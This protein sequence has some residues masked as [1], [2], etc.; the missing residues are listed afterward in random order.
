LQEIHLEND[1]NLHPCDLICVVKRKAVVVNIGPTNVC[2]SD[3]C[4]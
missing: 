2:A 4:T 1:E 3:V